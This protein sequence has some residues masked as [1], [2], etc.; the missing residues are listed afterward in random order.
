MTVR[1]LSE[2]SRLRLRAACER[3]GIFRDLPHMLH[4]QR[5]RDRFERDLLALIERNDNP[6]L[7][8]VAALLGAW[9]LILLKR[10]PERPLAILEGDILASEIAHSGLHM[11]DTWQ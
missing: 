2:P 7:H 6:P 5:K 11:M 1:T 3:A 10:V 8:E 9:F 4:A